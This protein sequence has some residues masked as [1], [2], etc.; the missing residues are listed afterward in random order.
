MKTRKNVKI[1]LI[2]NG[3]MTEWRSYGIKLHRTLME[4]PPDKVVIRLRDFYPDTPDHVT[5]IVDFPV[6]H[7]LSRETF[8]REEA[9]EKELERHID[10]REMDDTLLSSEALTLADS[11]E[12]EYLFNKAIQEVVARCTSDQRQRIALHIQGFSNVE[13][14]KLCQCH[15]AAVRK[16]LRKVKEKI[17]IFLTGGTN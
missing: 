2:N 1:R 9:L 8:L 17:N 16:S 3:V 14:A 11:A 15:E 10:D 7:V 6:F 4:N 13:I 12:D 5:Q